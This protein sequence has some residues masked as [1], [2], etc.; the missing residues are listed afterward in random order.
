MGTR[1]AFQSETSNGYTVSRGGMGRAGTVAARLLVER[2]MSPRAAIHAVRA[3]RTGAIE[4]R[5]QEA[6]VTALG[7]DY[8]W[9][10]E[11]HPD[12]KP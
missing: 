6:Y 2:G 3:V 5:S 12:R 1:L 11:A 7:Q 10:S 4:S 9:R 8:V